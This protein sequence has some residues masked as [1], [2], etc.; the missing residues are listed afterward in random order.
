MYKN[1]FV[2]FSFVH[3]VWMK[4]LLNV[5]SVS[6]EKRANAFDENVSDIMGIFQKRVHKMA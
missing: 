6:W 1:G 2:C 4:N 5:H 3:L